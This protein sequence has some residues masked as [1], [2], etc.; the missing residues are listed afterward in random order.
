[1][2]E[3]VWSGREDEGVVPG[4][5]CTAPSWRV[6]RS[7]GREGRRWTESGPRPKEKD[8]RLLEY[9]ESYPCPSSLSNVE[10][11]KRNGKRERG[12]NDES[13]STSGS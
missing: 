2:T 7:E 1:M 10:P 4:V 3:P 12:S 11:S 5:P 9:V 13:S 6:S 8:T